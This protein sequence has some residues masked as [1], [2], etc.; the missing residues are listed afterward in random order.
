MSVYIMSPQKVHTSQVHVT[1]VIAFLYP[2]QHGQSL[3]NHHYRMIQISHSFSVF[4]YHVLHVYFLQDIV[5]THTEYET[6]E[7]ATAQT[8][9][10]THYVQNYMCF[11]TAVA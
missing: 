2:C 6:M 11:Y 1:L 10:V 7:E 8:P 3:N 4:P 9:Q 5:L